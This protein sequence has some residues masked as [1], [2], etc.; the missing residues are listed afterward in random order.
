MIKMKVF[1]KASNKLVRIVEC[2]NMKAYRNELC[3]NVDHTKE[4]AFGFAKSK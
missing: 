1:N 2:A 4:Y 3:Y